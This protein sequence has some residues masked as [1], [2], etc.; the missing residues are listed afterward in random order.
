MRREITLS[1]L[2]P[3]F[4][5]ELPFLPTAI[6]VLNN[7]DQSVYLAI[8]GL[9]PPNATFYDR[10]ILP[11]ASGIPSNVALPNNSFQFAGYLPTP[12]DTTK[13]VNIIFQGTASPFDN[14]RASPLRN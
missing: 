12:T 14:R 7:T 2:I 10:E 4:S 1:N 13:K 3:T 9:L 8:G 11:A 6:I 5:I